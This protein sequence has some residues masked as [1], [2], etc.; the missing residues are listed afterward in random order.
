VVKANKIAGGNF[1]QISVKLDLCIQ[2]TM[3]ASHFYANCPKIYENEVCDFSQDDSG[4]TNGLGPLSR[5][6]K[7]WRFWIA[8]KLFGN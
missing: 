7:K 1:Y 4:K 8:G 5:K 6:R 2:E 3:H